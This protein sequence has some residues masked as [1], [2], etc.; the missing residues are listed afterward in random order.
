MLGLDLVPI[1]FRRRGPDPA[2][3]QGKLVVSQHSTLEWSPLRGALVRPFS[4]PISVKGSV[5]FFRIPRMVPV[6]LCDA[7][8]FPTRYSFEGVDPPYSICLDFF[9]CYSR[10]VPLGPQPVPLTFVREYRPPAS[11]FPILLCSASSSE[12][13]LVPAS[14]SVMLAT[15]EPAHLMR[16]G[17]FFKGP[18]LGVGSMFPTHLERIA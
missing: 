6:M 2:L 8:R 1:L 10:K 4:S 13:N 11:L 3:V 14:R 5:P 16:V 9:P 12:G 7:L 18:P 17:V 15:M